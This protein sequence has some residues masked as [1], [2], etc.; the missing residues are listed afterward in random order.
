MKNEILDEVWRARDEIA[1]ECGHDLQKLGAMLR[2]EEAK[3]GARLA[4]LPIRRRDQTNSNVN[5]E[6][7]QYGTGSSSR[8]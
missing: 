2:R 4:R 8:T 3:Y 7:P 6:L 5:E 1:A